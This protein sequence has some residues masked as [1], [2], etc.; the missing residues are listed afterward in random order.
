MQTYKRWSENF[1]TTLIF[2][3]VD[4]YYG[5]LNCGVCLD[6]I[7]RPSTL[8]TAQDTGV[9][10]SLIGASHRALMQRIAVYVVPLYFGDREM[11]QGNILVT[12]RKPLKSQIRILRH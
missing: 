5:D 7:L 2:L 3:F 10:Y 6:Q 9:E 4:C 11:R 8:L 1:A 12:S